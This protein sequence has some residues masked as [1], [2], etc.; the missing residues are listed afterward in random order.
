[1][2]RKRNAVHLT[3]FAIQVGFF[4]IFPEL[5]S[6]AFSGVRYLANQIAAREIIVWNP[7][8]AA[9]VALLA[10]TVL[11]GRFFCGYACAFG[12]I[13]DWAFAYA[14]FILRRSGKKPL[15]LPDKAVSALLYAKYAVLAAILAACLLQR[16][17]LVD[18]ADP[19]YAFALLRAGNFDLSGK[20]WA[21]VLLGL[22]FIGMLFVERFFCMFL[23]P[24]GAVFTLLPMLPFTLYNRKKEECI[25][26]CA[27]CVKACPAAI[28]LG[29]S[30]SKYGDCFQC[31]KCGAECPKS[32]IKSGFRKLRAAELWLAVPKAALLL[33]ICHLVVNA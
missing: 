2:K 18:G 14:S 6:L 25:P 33:A 27:R 24:L 23:C 30:D 1:M 8:L 22:I 17:S 26:G 4:I 29:E 19:W 3:R 31:G 13:G 28:S 10:F 32:N 15:R 20:M 5:F 16:Y 12:S 11:F 21:T 9:L 7:F